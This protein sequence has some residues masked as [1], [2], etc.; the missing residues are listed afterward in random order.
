MASKVDEYSEKELL[1][2]KIRNLD[3]RFFKDD[4]VKFCMVQDPDEF[5]TWCRFNDFVMHGSTRLIPGKLKP[6]LAH[7]LS[8]SFGN[9][10]GIY[11]IT[12]PIVAMFCALAGG[13]DVG[14]RRNSVR[15]KSSNQTLSYTDVFFGVERI[16]E[17]KSEGYVYIFDK[18][19]TDANEGPEYISF[20]PVTPLLIL[21]I[22]KTDFDYTINEISELISK[23]V[24]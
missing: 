9:Q 7:D 3:A 1:Q 4:D 21:K 8:K 5:L 22:M 14:L 16:D 2:R 24:V 18:R 10:K 19:Q 13:V 15:T 23:S 12:T 20:S 6:S 17:V 11:S